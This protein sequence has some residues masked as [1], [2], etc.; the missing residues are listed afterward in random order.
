MRVQTE[1]LTKKQI[2]SLPRTTRWRAKK[3]GW[4]CVAKP[5]AQKARARNDWVD[6]NAYYAVIETV[7]HDAK[8]A[9]RWARRTM[10]H[11]CWV[12]LDDLEQEALLV[13]LRNSARPNFTNRTWRITVM[14]NRLRDLSRKRT[15]EPLTILE[16]V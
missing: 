16:E 13:L 9:A 15:D 3:R 2:D 12:T 1:A 8:S 10:S 11:P 14:R 6:L 7:L 4:I 5:R